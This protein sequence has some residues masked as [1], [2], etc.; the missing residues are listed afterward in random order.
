[1]NRSPSLLAALA[2]L[3]VGA[4]LALACMGWVL[5]PPDTGPAAIAVAPDAP[6]AAVQ[7]QRGPGTPAPAPDP[8]LG[9][10]SSPEAKAYAQQIMKPIRALQRCRLPIHYTC[11]E[12]GCVVLLEGPE[13]SSQ[14]LRMMAEAWPILLQEAATNALDLPDES[15]ECTG[16]IRGLV[17]QSNEMVKTRHT[18]S[19]RST[20]GKV[21]CAVYLRE[22]P[23]PEDAEAM[24]AVEDT[25]ALRCDALLGASGAVTTE[26]H[27]ELL[28]RQRAAAEP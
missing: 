7:A 14:Q 26:T 22:P 20:R 23:D 4:A 2:A 19:L 15:M 3:A 10:P 27:L 13:T 9:P 28:D 16:A 18:E 8:V 24:A 12:D 6:P 25:R 5:Q 17:D 11:H 1:M 21:L